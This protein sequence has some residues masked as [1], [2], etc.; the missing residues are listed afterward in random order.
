M[1][2]LAKILWPEI[3]Q[4]FAFCYHAVDDFNQHCFKQWF[5]FHVILSEIGSKFKALSY[6]N[7]FDYAT[8]QKQLWSFR[9]SFIKNTVII[10][11]H[12]AE[13]SKT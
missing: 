5:I 6:G 3:S 10:N 11:I 2:L 7:E 12:D 1:I 8:C 9:L 13:Q 4:H